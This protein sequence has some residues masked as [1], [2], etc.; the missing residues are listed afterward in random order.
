M[1]EIVTTSP[2]YH[3]YTIQI[4]E[5]GDW[6][7]KFN[8]GDKELALSKYGECLINE[9]ESTFR[10][11]ENKEVKKQ[12]TEKPFRKWKEITDTVLMSSDEEAF[13]LGQISLIE[14]RA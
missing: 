2:S 7:V 12:T 8:T 13:P 10:L 4:Y 14:T 6:S 3:L 9:F 1:S 11:V 5:H